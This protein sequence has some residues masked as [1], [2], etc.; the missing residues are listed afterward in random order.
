[1]DALP[2]FI[3]NSWYYYV[4]CMVKNSYN[5]GHDMQHKKFG[6]AITIN[7][8]P[9]WVTIWSAAW[10]LLNT[11]LL[12]ILMLH[13]SKN[14]NTQILHD[15]LLSDHLEGEIYNISCNCFRKLLAILKP[16]NFMTPQCHKLYLEMYVITSLLSVL[17][18]QWEL[19]NNTSIDSYSTNR[20]H[21]MY[22]SVLLN[23]LHFLGRHPPYLHRSNM[24]FRPPESELTGI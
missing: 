4:Y 7:D 9:V 24:T 8:L 5:Y 19:H 11:L 12:N 6:L 10:I 16:Q 1:M 18:S 3:I 15:L 20:M 14:H 21:S 17:L 22:T 13:S 2:N 23:F